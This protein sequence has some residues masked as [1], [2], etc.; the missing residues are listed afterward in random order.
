MV[1]NDLE[2]CINFTAY[3]LNWTLSSYL[4]IFVC[5]NLSNNSIQFNHNAKHFYKNYLKPKKNLQFYL[6]S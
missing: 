4:V 2:R 6:K 1:A 5:V 3:N